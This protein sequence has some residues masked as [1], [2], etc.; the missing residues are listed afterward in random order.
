MLKRLAILAS[1][2]VLAVCVSGQPNKAADPNQH[3]GHPEQPVIV[4]ASPEKQNESGADKAKTDPDPPKWYAPIERPDWWLVIL[5]FGTLV[6]VGWQTAILGKSVSVAKTAADAAEISAKAAMGVAVPTLVLIGFDFAEMGVASFAA[7]LQHPEMRVVVKNY[8]Q[9]PAFLKSYALKYSCEGIKLTSSIPN[10][11]HFEDG[12]VIEAGQEYVLQDAAYTP[13]QPF[14]VEDIV[15][16]MNQKKTLGIAGCL[17]YG[18]VFGSPS[19]P[20]LFC[21][22]LADFRSDGTGRLWVEWNLGEKYR[23]STE[24]QQ[25]PKPN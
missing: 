14:S 10:A 19:R 16:I 12:T 21:K 1:A 22:E 11:Y 5:G 6:V 17:W 23:V 3:P 24:E 25:P 18:D 4:K 15:A 8:G 2:A 20:L 7:K 13:W 9:T